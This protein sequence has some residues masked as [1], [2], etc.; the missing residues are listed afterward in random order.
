MPITGKSTNCSEKPCGIFVEKDLTLL[1]K[2]KT[3]M[4]S[5]SAM[6]KTSL[7]D[8]KRISKIFQI[9]SPPHHQKNTSYI[10]GKENKP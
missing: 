9:Q 2:S 6:R 4:M 3:K 5:H 8:G 1:D 7:A 10:F